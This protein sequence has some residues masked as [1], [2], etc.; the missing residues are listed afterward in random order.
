VTDLLYGLAMLGAFALGIGGLWMW[1]RDRKRALLL[2]AAALA[3]LVNVL[4]WS[5]LPA[6][7]SAGGLGVVAPAAR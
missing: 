2:I 5:T 1:R 3:T 4:S 7:Q 6:P